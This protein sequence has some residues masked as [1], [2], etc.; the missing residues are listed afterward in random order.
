ML[1]SYLRKADAI[2]NDLQKQIKV[3]NSYASIYA[4]GIVDIDGNTYNI[5]EIGSQVWMIDNLKTSRYR[6]GDSIPIIIDNLV[7]G[8]LTTGAR[9]WYDNDS[10]T[11]EVPYGNLY[12]SFAIKDLRGICP[13]GWHVPSQED[14]DELIYFLGG[15]DIAGSKMRASDMLYWRHSP[16][17]STDNESGFSA[18]P[19]G[20]R[21]YDGS[22][23]GI[24][25][26]A[27]FWCDLANNNNLAWNRYMAYNYSY[28]STNCNSKAFGFSVRCLRDK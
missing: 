2:I 8:N 22:F 17:S 13:S 19:G 7:W 15:K 18:L 5:V 14:W 3:L 20:N 10:L 16:L 28:F 4:K 11:Y 1:N 25:Y 26:L 6:N 27:F 24:R 21:D 9:C 12:N 23:N